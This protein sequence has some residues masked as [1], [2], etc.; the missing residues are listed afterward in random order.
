MRVNQR[1]ASPIIEGTTI[2]GRILMNSLLMKVFCGLLLGVLLTS[3]WA[4]AQQALSKPAV[5]PE[6]QQRLD[7]MK[8]KG[9]EASLTILPVRLGGKPF[10]RVTEVIGLILEQQGL[11]NIELGETVFDPPTGADRQGLADA[12]GEFVKGHPVTTDYVMYAEINGSR[13]TG[14]NELR[15]V[16]ADNEGAVVWTE[17]QTPQHEAFRGLESPNPMSLSVLLVERLSPNL[18]LNEETAK[19]AKPGKMAALMDE[20]SGMPPENERAPLPERQKA[21]KESL[22]NATLMVFPVRMSGEANAASA[23]DLEKMINEAG[24]CK[25]ISAEESVLLKAP[26]ADPNEM[27]I[28]WGLAREFRVYAREN[29]TDA[30]YVLYAD[31]VFNPQKWEQGFVHFVVCDNKGEWVIVDMQNSHHP[32]YQSIK[33]VSKEDC[34]KLLVKRLGSYLIED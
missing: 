19:A 31:Y 5:S 13:E 21:M 33:P 22:Q 11:M 9:T 30:D 20:R 26:Q 15:A 4:G 18:G 7:L 1:V 32:D 2:E 23:A 27:K 12:V 16:V 24:L 17:L 34:S 25:A 14:I 28:L 29:P 10:D 8:S 6:Q 3:G